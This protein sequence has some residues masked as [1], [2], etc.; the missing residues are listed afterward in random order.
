ML[1]LLV[2]D[3]LVAAATT[4]GQQ[5]FKPVSVHEHYLEYKNRLNIQKYKISE[6]LVLR[7]CVLAIACTSR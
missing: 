3:A 7:L 5:V 6:S 2:R 1:A 4:A